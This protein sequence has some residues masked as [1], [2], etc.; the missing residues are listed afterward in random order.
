MNRKAEEKIDPQQEI[1]LLREEIE[2]HNH[3]YYVLDDPTISDADY[4]R[5]FDRLIELERAHP[6]LIT[7]DSP[8]QKVG[9]APLTSFKTVRHTLPMH[10]LSNATD[11]ED[12]EEFQDRIQRF[13]KTTDPIEYVAEPKVDGV[14]V[15]LVYEIG[16]FTL[17]STRGDGIEGED[18]TLNLATIRSLPMRLRTEQRN[19]PERLELRGEVYLP[20]IAFQKLNQQREEDG[21]AV[22][23]NPRNAAAG[24]LKQLDSSITAKRP[25]DF[26]LHGRGVISGVAFATQFEF[27]DAVKNWGLKPVPLRRLCRGLDEALQYAAEIETRRDTLPFEIDG[28]VVKVNSAELQRRLGEI[29][30]SPRWAI[31]FKFKTRQASTRIG[32]I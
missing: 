3:R 23:A 14:A 18:I 19:A 16:A 22:F 28:I 21:Q 9:A 27:L 15:E 6:G 4:D 31:A 29:A 8:T 17:G 25:L 30:R 2:R 10:S 7:P 13:L 32:D 24:S 11:R 26:F 1:A 12:M 20:R 5:L